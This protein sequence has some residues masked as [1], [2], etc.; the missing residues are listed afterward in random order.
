MLST[1]LFSCARKAKNSE[2]IVLNRSNNEVNKFLGNSGIGDILMTDQNQLMS[3]METEYEIEM[4]KAKRPEIREKIRTLPTVERDFWP[5][6]EASLERTDKEIIIPIDFLDAPL[7]ATNKIL[8][9]KNQWEILREI[10]KPLT[11]KF[12]LDKL[13][14][15]DSVQVLQR[16][17][18]EKIYFDSEDEKYSGASMVCDVTNEYHDN[19]HLNN[20]RV[21]DRLLAWLLKFGKISTNRIKVKDERIIIEYDFE[22]LMDLDISGSG[23]LMIQLLPEKEQYEEKEDTINIHND[24]D[25]KYG[26][27]RDDHLGVFYQKN[28]YGKRYLSRWNPKSLPIGLSLHSSVYENK[29]VTM[30]IW[31]AVDQINDAIHDYGILNDPNDKLVEVIDRDEVETDYVDSQTIYLSDIDSDLTPGGTTS[32]EIDKNTG[33]I[34]DADIVIYWR[35]IITDFES[36]LKHFL[37]LEEKE[38]IFK[39]IF[40]HELLHLLGVAH[41]FYG[42]KYLSLMDYYSTRRNMFMPYRLLSDYDLLALKYLYTD[43]YIYPREYQNFKVMREFLMV[44]SSYLI[45]ELETIFYHCSNFEN[46]DKA[47]LVDCRFL[48]SFFNRMNDDNSCSYWDYSKKAEIRDL[49]M[50]ECFPDYE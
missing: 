41:N 23:R 42:H 47:L 35:N 11:Y 40:S 43:E 44:Q 16:L 26:Y 7:V 3:V 36:D 49:I 22:K 27:S 19:V 29:E 33:E 20:C 28:K 45:S 10:K 21:H 8:F 5:T 14:F 24:R 38:R 2:E 1:A 32:F 6:S 34:F 18:G 46:I 12:L 30:W 17:E 15:H 50:K 4:K 39:G 48:K 25:D 13:M 31:E 9:F 37:T